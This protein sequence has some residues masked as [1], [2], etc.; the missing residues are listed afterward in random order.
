MNLQLESIQ[1]FDKTTELEQMILERY[2][3]ILR[4]GKFSGKIFLDLGIKGKEINMCV[5]KFKNYI[6]GISGLD[7]ENWLDSTDS[8][9]VRVLVSEFVSYVSL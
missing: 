8:E 6:I 3:S 9:Q 1:L 5:E 2:K 4:K 7:F